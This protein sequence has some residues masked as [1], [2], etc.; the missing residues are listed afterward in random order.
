MTMRC[1]VAQSP[2]ASCQRAWS[3]ALS[4]AGGRLADAERRSD[5]A[6]RACGAHAEHRRLARELRDVRRER[7]PGAREIRERGH[8]RA[9]LR[10]HEEVQR[11]GP[12]REELHPLARHAR[13][14]RSG[15]KD[16]LERRRRL[17]DVV[18]EIE[19][20]RGHRARHLD[21]LDR[22]LD[23]GHVRPAARGDTPPRERDHLGALLDA[24]D[25][26]ARA[27]PRLEDVEREAGPAA[28]V[29][30]R[31]AGPQRE[32]LDGAAAERRGA[33]R[34]RVVARRVLAVTPDGELG[35]LGGH[36]AQGI[37]HPEPGVATER[38]FG[39]HCARPGRSCP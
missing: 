11:R 29:E 36:D 8:V 9:R 17:Q 39:R 35:A 34:G 18:H 21:V 37:M 23:Q 38:S 20:Q 5:S 7:S 12:P 15:C 13:A 22:A 30:D 1:A 24:D 3:G 32:P 33:L 27:D 26:P 25:P 14:G 2:F 4:P 31:I 28:D 6:V 10:Q 16:A 19:E